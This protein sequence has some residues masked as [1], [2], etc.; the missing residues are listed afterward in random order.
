[1]AN[2]GEYKDSIQGGIRPILITSN[3]VSNQKSNFV[4]CIPLTSKYKC[5]PN[6][7]YLTKNNE[8]GLLVGSI[9]LAEQERPLSKDDIIKYIGHLSDKQLKDVAKA[10]VIQRPFLAMAIED[11]SFMNSKLFEHVCA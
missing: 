7:A 8:N 5:L 6:H 9:A 4:N 1:M 3:N 11:D 2:L 10:Y